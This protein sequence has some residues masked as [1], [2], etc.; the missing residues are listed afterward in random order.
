MGE[1]LLGGEVFLLAKGRVENREALIGDAQ[2]VRGEM[3]AKFLPGAIDGFGGHR[4]ESHLGLNSVNRPERGLGGCL[5]SCPEEFA[6]RPARVVFAAAT[7]V[8]LNF[9]RL[10]DKW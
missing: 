5:F 2:A 4:P 7:P 9:I 3:R 1:Q 6:V 10:L 8:K